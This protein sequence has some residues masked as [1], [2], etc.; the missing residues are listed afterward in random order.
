MISLAHA[1]DLIA[2]RIRA[3]PIRQRALAELRQPRAQMNPRATRKIKAERPRQAVS[4]QAL[5]LAP[6]LR[7]QLRANADEGQAETKARS[8]AKAKRAK[9]KARAAFAMGTGPRPTESRAEV[10]RKVA[11]L[12]HVTRPR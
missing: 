1:S 11:K 6:M 8:A 5:K 10:E 3:E 9:A 4:A 2:K 12:F 7:A